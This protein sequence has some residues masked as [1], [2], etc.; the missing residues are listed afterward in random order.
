[1]CY[2]IWPHDLKILRLFIT[3]FLW[4]LWDGWN[5]GG[6]AECHI[7]IM[8]SYFDLELDTEQLPSPPTISIHLN[9]K[10]LIKTCILCRSDDDVGHA[11][12][13]VIKKLSSSSF[14]W[15]T[16][17]HCL[18]ITVFCWLSNVTLWCGDNETLERKL[19]LGATCH[20]VGGKVP[21]RIFI[22]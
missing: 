9:L 3:V 14:F 15:G 21:T 6:T 1:M 8:S 17:G 22:G 7:V 11:Y 19:H 10:Y 18:A 20:L 16:G 13:L 4:H 5:T 2:I 12:F